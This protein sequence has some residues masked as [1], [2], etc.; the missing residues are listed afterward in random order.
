MEKEQRPVFKAR[1]APK[2]KPRPPLVKIPKV[3]NTI[4]NKNNTDKPLNGQAKDDN[5][6]KENRPL[7]QP[8]AGPR[9]KS[10]VIASKINAKIEKPVPSV[11]PINKIRVSVAKDNIEMRKSTN[12]SKIPAPTIKNEFLTP[13]IPVKIN[14][15]TQTTLTSIQVIKIFQN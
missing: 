3:T 2:M 8:K 10:Y 13:K 15:N 6:S 5:S 1:P 14:K 7:D 12:S 4:N 9:Q 11:N